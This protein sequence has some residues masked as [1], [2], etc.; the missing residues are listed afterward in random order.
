MG[1]RGTSPSPPKGGQ[2]EMA[3]QSERQNDWWMLNYSW[4]G[5]LDGRQMADIP[6]HLMMLHKMFQHVSEQGQKEAEC[7]VCQGHQQGLPKL[8]PK[9]NI[10][11]VQ[12][13]GA[14]TSRREIESLYYEVYK[15]QRLPGFPPRSQSS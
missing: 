12:L 9:V 1:V 3:C 2:I 14:Q 10:S 4:R 8:D 5:R 6:H 15:L 7:M 13:V 11:A